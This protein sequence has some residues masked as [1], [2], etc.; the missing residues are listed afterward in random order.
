V[1]SELLTAVVQTQIQTVEEIYRLGWTAVA[2]RSARGG[3]AH[4][5]IP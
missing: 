5:A 3:T 1:S 4:P 2:N